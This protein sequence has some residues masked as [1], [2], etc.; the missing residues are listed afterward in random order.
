ML[1]VF[2]CHLLNLINVL[3]EAEVLESLD[4]VFCRNRLFCLF[5]GDLVGLRGDERDE[6][7]AAFDEEVA[8]VLSEGKVV[9]E[10]FL[11][12]LLD[13]RCGEGF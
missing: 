13:R 11:N 1:L 6:F 10:D 2:L 12:Y 5:F 8:G 4:D 7:D 3:L 9:G